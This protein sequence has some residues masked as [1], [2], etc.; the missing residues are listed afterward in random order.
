M[1]LDY[2]PGCKRIA[3]SE[4]YLEA[5]CKP[6]VIVIPSGVDQ[7]KGRTIIDKHGN[8]TEVD[9]LILATGFDIQ[10][11]AGNLQSKLLLITTSYQYFYTLD[12]IGEKKNNSYCLFTIF[13]IF[14]FNNSS[15]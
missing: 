10:G 12:N 3:K 1:V 9:I 2:P 5:L 14:D 11:F 13:G 6:N 7:I 8:E 4:L 15:W